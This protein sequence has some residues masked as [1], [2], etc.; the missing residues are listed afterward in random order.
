MYKSVLLAYDSSIE[1]AKALREGALLARRCGADVFLLSVVPRSADVQMAEG[2]FAGIVVGQT[3]SYKALLSRAVARLTDLGMK[4]RARLLVGEP[5][6]VIGQ[7]AREIGADLVVVGHRQ[8][9]LISRWWFGST[10]AY[11]SDH[12]SCSLLLAR[13]SISDET[14]EAEMR[15]P[16]YSAN[17]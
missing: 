14:F 3:D 7:V 5:A 8:Q 13:T 15:V 17:D 2:T 12:I 1:G 16:A 6:A 11:L 4:P 9:T 10:G